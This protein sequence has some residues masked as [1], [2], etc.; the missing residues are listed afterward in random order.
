MAQADVQI[1]KSV[2]VGYD[3]ADAWPDLGKGEFGSAVLT[4]TC[5]LQP[6]KAGRDWALSMCSKAFQMVI[7]RGV[8]AWS[9]W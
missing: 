9:N 5:T 8:R 2:S 6:R 7:C 4:K 3:S 1:Y